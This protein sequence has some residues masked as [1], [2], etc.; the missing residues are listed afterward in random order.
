MRFPRQMVRSLLLPALSLIAAAAPASADHLVDCGKESLS[1]AVEAFR[2]KDPVISFTGVCP[3]PIVI[4]I[5]GI[6]LKGVDTAIIDGGGQH[7]VITVVGAGRV[8]L[9][10]FE[11]RNGRNGIVAVNGAHLSLSDLNV[12]DNLVRGISLQTGSTAVLTDVTTRLNGLHGLDLQTGSS[13]T[14][15]GTLTAS[16]NRVFGINVNGSAITFSLATV[17][18]GRNALGVQIATNANAFLNDSS[19]VINATE[20][21]ATGL[22]VVSGAHLV[23]FGGRINASGIPVVGVSV[24]SG[25]G[26]DLDAASVLN[27]TNNGDGLLVQGEAVM[28]VFNTPQFSGIPG[29][30]TINTTNNT[31]N[32]VRV[33]RGSTLT[34]VNQA[35]IVSTQNG[36]VGLVADNGTGVTLVNSIIKGNTVRD[37]QLTFGTRADFQT[38]DFGTATC[39]STVL[40][41]GSSGITCP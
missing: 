8:T 17:T 1:A 12:H 9:A 31:L 40:I 27:S 37:I 30:S 41:R 32:G 36:A 21:L 11:V 35:R 19:T 26:L 18:A 33:L 6:S 39:D 25:A 14:V 10:E 15:T 5:D 7:D 28:T 20:N 23:S 16:E 29:F 34:L 13:A 22:T 3:G 24:S 2:D 38:L 4:R